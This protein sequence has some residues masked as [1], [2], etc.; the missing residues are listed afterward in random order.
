[1]KDYKIKSIIF[2]I[3]VFLSI[4]TY[5]YQSEQTDLSISSAHN[6]VSRMN[7]FF[8]NELISCVNVSVVPELRKQQAQNDIY[9][10]NLY[11]PI[12][13]LL[14]VIGL[15]IFKKELNI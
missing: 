5:V 11:L 4:I 12:V 1:M 3:I 7:G 13:L 10:Y 2:I 14:I 8:E 9:S 15:I 6:C